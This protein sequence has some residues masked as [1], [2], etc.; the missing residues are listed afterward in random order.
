MATLNVTQIQ[1]GITLIELNRPEVR[2][3]L[4]ITLMESLQRAIKS[5][6]S[7]PG[8]RVIILTGAGPVFCAG[9]DL[10][11]GSDNEKAHAMA[12]AI[13]NTLKILYACP[14]VTI[15]AIQGAAMAGGAGIAT[16]CDLIVAAEGTKIAYPETRRGLIA[17]LV[18][19]ILR[20][21][22]GDR[23]VRELLLTAEPISAERAFNIGLI[24]RI[25]PPQRLVPEC[26]SI[27]NTV[28]HGA[29]EATKLTKMLLDEL[30]AT[31]LENDI[32]RALS[33]HFQARNSLE[34]QEG[35][36]AFN[37]KREPVW[38][39]ELNINK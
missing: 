13:A 27:A 35:I 18:M 3:A 37:E 31:R 24:N 34:A 1:P 38:E 4:N 28:L 23:L 17:A 32:N 14:L 29:P 9:L 7:Q 8:Q 22:I 39:A 30:H 5:I 11:E 15:A 19:A 26:L 2:N 36:N 16:A 12:E 21:Q 20:R 25:V 10:K 33:Y 6:S